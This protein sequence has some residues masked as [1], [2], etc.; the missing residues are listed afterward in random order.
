MYWI[1]MFYSIYT[2]YSNLNLRVAMWKPG[3]SQMYYLP[4]LR[5]RALLLFLMLRLWH[6]NVFEDFGGKK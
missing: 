2:T 3:I 6:A 5:T 4:M 1:Q